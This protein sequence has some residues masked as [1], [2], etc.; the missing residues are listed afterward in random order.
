[1]SQGAASA[2]VRA[3]LMMTTVRAAA[4]IA[5]G[6]AAAGGVV[7]A[8]VAALM[9]GVMKAMLLSKLKNVMAVLAFLGLLGLGVGSAAYQSVAAEP[10]K[11]TERLALNSPAPA[12]A[13]KAKSEEK[14]DLPKNFP[15]QQVLAQ[16]DKDGQFIVKRLITLA[17]PV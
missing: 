3:T 1:M 7:S 10:P 8:P 2:A 9:E 17:I 14:P 11:T 15:P 6:Q 5:A 12:P 16:V 4:G 13:E